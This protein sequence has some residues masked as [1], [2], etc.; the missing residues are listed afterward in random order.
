[1]IKKKAGVDGSRTHR[2]PQRDPPPILKTE[3]PTGAQPL[4]RSG[5][6]I[7]QIPLMINPFDSRMV[8]EG[9]LWR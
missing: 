9:I 8:L 3:E 1:M 4:P 2:G 6:I 7:P 5:E